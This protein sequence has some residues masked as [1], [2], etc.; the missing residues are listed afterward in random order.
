MALMGSLLGLGMGAVVTSFLPTKYEACMKLEIMKPDGRAGSIIPS[1]FK[2]EF[3]LINSDQVL[4]LAADRLDLAMMWNCNRNEAIRQLG[5]LVKTDSIKGTDLITITV[6]HLDREMVAKIANVVADAYC[7]SRRDLD[8]QEFER[9]MRELKRVMR[10]QEALVEECRK[11][12]VKVIRTQGRDILY[13]GSEEKDA[14]GARAMREAGLKDEDYLEAKR[15]FES[16]LEILQ[17]MKVKV[18]TE[19]I[20]WKMGTD[21]TRVHDR[22]AEPERP[23]L[24]N[25]SLN[26]LLAA[27]LGLLG[28]PLLA[29]PC[30]VLLHRVIPPQAA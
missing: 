16:E 17:S 3:D 10:V 11:V 23:V 8:D 13:M 18:I 12:L 4:G 5:E 2:I 22:A 19:E 14:D 6:R 29:W 25:M 30:I 20:T 27:V 1:L 7:K 15:M 21:H 28:S 26:L 24:P 9:G